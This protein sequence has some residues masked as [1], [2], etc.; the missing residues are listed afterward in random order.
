MNKLVDVYKVVM[1]TVDLGVGDYIYQSCIMHT[2]YG[3]FCK[4]PMVE[5]K[6]GRPTRRNSGCGP[7]MAFDNLIYAAYFV[8]AN[9]GKYATYICIFKAKA[10][11]SKQCNA[12]YTLSDEWGDKRLVQA[13]REFPKGSI[14]CNSIRI[15]E[16][17]PRKLWP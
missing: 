10:E 9:Y 8:V 15:E 7:L 11:L 13:N 12:W 5:Y 3:A 16:E 2:D 1:R 6:M 14:F 4:S 17:V